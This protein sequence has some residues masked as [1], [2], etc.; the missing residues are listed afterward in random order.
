MQKSQ[1]TFAQVAP[2]VACDIS[3]NITP[4]LLGEPGIGKSSLVEA[5]ERDLK[6]RV[7][8]LPCN[9]LADRSDLT[10]VR[11]VQNKET[12]NWGQIAFPH[13]TIL[14]AIEYA[15]A[16]PNETPILFLDE[17]NRA[18][19]DITSSILSFITLRRVG[20]MD[21]PPNLRL[22]VA[23]NDKGNVTSVD[24]AS[25]TRFSVY[26]VRPDIETFFRVNPD[27][28]AY[29]RDVLSRYPEDLMADTMVSD[30]LID[31]DED[32]DDEQNEA[33]LDA[34]DFGE[35]SFAQLTRPRTITNLSK[36]L[37]AFGLD[38]SGSD[39]ERELLSAYFADMSVGQNETLLYVAITSKV[40]NTAFA[41]HL[42]EAIQSHFNSMLSQ[43]H[44]SA[45]PLLAHLRPQQTVINDLSR[46]TDSQSVEAV[47]ATL[48]EDEVANTL[49]W[50]TES[51]NVKEIN[52]NN[53]VENFMANA[54]HQVSAF[55]NKVVQNLMKVLSDS[56]RR[57][58]LAV[59]AF[60][61]STAPVMTTWRSVIQSVVDFD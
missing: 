39:K 33:F 23:G 41:Q 48:T 45:A 58:D 7:F 12:G 46:A 55:E 61:G 54:P 1:L 49:V 18:S 28:N 53:A 40:G 8:T 50:L 29:V 25:V 16:H 19:S 37:N 30:K 32:E 10:G 35:E 51:V 21:F 15:E 36:W 38:K 27:M 26:H 44:T 6:T 57:S 22:M 31:A 60:M 3:A 9:Q 59:K 56:P 52:N 17:F 5:L 34:E 13:Q 2:F 11:H 4:T 20:T 24:S 14:E 47:I 42:Y 43:T